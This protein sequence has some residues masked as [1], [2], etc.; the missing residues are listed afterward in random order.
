MILRVTLILKEQKEIQ[1]WYVD[2]WKL[3][4]SDYQGFGK[5]N[6]K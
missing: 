3:A 6:K 1:E 2:L 5:K 4:F